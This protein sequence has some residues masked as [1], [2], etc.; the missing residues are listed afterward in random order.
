MDFSLNL[1]LINN[2]DN[3]TNYPKNINIKKEIE[4]V[5]SKFQETESESTPTEK[6]IKDL[7]NDLMF[8]NIEGNVNIVDKKLKESE[9]KFLESKKE[10]KNKGLCIEFNDLPKTII[11]QEEINKYLD[12]TIKDKNRYADILPYSHSIV[13]LSGEDK[14]INAN[15]IEGINRENEYIA[16][17][18]PVSSTITDFWRMIIEQEVEI[19]VMLTG[20][21]EKN[22]EKCAQYYPFKE[23]VKDVKDK[24]NNKTFEITNIK[25]EQMDEYTYRELEISYVSKPSEPIRTV[26]QYHYTAWP[27]H[28]VLQN[29]IDLINF[30][31]AVKQTETDNPIVVHCSAGVGRTGT[32]IAFDIY[33]NIWESQQPFNKK[34]EDFI[35]K[36]KES[37]QK[38]IDSVKINGVE[39]KKINIEIDPTYSSE[40][41]SPTS[42][43]KILV[44]M[45]HQRNYLVQNRHQY[46]YLVDALIEYLEQKK[47]N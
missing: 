11:R 45:R 26:K 1:N 17:Q 33:A 27:D 6:T 31:K 22:I 23:G 29:P 38:K 7:L 10:T 40:V 25:T 14:Y 42:I 37:V 21:I 46:I 5:I 19:I 43:Q 20:I 4:T 15:Y 9:I 12:V 30:R 18:G 2:E 36:S 35:K 3:F 13:K 41:E 44:L 39:L 28:G 8:N 32:F 34:F 24:N 47:I 16:T